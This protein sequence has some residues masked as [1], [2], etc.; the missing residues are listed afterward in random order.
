MVTVVFFILHFRRNTVDT[1]VKLTDKYIKTPE[2]WKSILNDKRE[3]MD[4]S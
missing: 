2:L 3:D 1:W 4:S